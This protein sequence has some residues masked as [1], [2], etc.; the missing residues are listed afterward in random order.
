M[1]RHANPQ[2]KVK[3]NLVAACYVEQQSEIQ[4]AHTLPA[5]KKIKQNKC[6]NSLHS[7]NAHQ[8]ET[9]T[10]TITIDV[11]QHALKG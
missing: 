1:R 4:C 6:D 11:T 5:H 7:I 3:H 10:T 9:P 8:N 2:K